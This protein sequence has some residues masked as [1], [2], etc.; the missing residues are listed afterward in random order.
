[1][2]GVT[3]S[4]IRSAANCPHKLN[5]C[6]TRVAPC[7][8]SGALIEP[9][10]TLP[11]LLL[12]EKWNSGGVGYPDGGVLEMQLELKAMAAR[13]GNMTSRDG[14]TRYETHLAVVA[15]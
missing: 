6:G 3:K 13:E 14:Q 4:S 10:R 12:S 2:V 11:E 9:R 5:S 15:V 1:M 8:G 7:A